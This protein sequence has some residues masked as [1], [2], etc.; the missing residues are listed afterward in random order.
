[1]GKKGGGQKIMRACFT[2]GIAKEG[3]REELEKL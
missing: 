1:V 2:R 3:F